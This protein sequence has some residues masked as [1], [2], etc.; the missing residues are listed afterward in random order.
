MEKKNKSRHKDREMRITQDQMLSSQQDQEARVDQDQ[1]LC[2]KQNRVTRNDRERTRHIQQDRATKISHAQ[3][4][5]N[6]QDRAAWIN[7]DQTITNSRQEEE[8]NPVVQE[9]H[10][11]VDA[12]LE[13]TSDVDL[14][15]IMGSFSTNHLRLVLA[16]SSDSQSTVDNK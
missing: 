16:F 1:A 14:A 10:A 13:A 3:V 5:I 2:R 4:V 11:V 9:F 15:E 12:I 7:E 6:R 8:E